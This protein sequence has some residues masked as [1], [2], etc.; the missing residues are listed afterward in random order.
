M[1][2]GVESNHFENVLEQDCSPHVTVT[3]HS[4]HASASET[5]RP[6]RRGPGDPLG[7]ITGPCLR[8]IYYLTN[9]SGVPARAT[10]AG[11]NYVPQCTLAGP[12]RGPWQRLRLHRKLNSLHGVPI[13]HC[14]TNL[15]SQTHDHESFDGA[16]GRSC[17]RYRFLWQA[18]YDKL[19]GARG[20]FFSLIFSLLLLYPLQSPLTFLRP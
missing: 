5:P 1:P 20:P 16:R 10:A 11:T 6:G 15:G 8:G 12:K 2:Q 4:L 14:T 17:C 19:K 13:P 3:N 7:A 18:L 9:C